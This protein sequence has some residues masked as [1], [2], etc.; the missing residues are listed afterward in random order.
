V[1][2]IAWK[3][4]LLDHPS[5]IK[6][7]RAPKPRLGG[8][9]FYL[10]WLVGGGLLYL[11]GWCPLEEYLFV[12]LLG[13]AFLAAG[14]VDDLH[15][16]Q[17]GPKIAIL[18]SIS[19]AAIALLPGGGWTRSP[20]GLLFSFL[21]VLGLIN[22]VNMVDG[23]DGLAGTTVG[24]SVLALA[25]GLM[26]TGR[27]GQGILLLPLAGALAGFLIWNAPPAR[28]FMG[29]GGSTLLGFCLG[30]FSL[31]GAGPALTLGSLGWGLI[32]GV[33]VLELLTTIVRR[34]RAH[35]A[36][37]GGDLEHTYNR[38]IRERWSQRRVLLLFAFLSLLAG[39]GGIAM[40][41]TPVLWIQGMILA[42]FLALGISIALK[43]HL[44]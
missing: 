24:I 40:V 43:W 30:F 25:V 16:L 8:V 2:R 19:I 7:H 20:G 27:I 32:P 23:L 42:C 17:P 5:T 29:D 22:A 4:N 35:Q 6:T 15:T 12:F 36:L 1:T 38:L 9:G 14:I 11:E 13:G 26:M 37:S 34:L 21:W 31:I 44:V 28:I 39:T 41:V 3:R 10:G 18:A 33:F